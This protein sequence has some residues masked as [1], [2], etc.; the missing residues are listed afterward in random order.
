MRDV[1]S[2]RRHRGFVTVAGA[3]VAGVLVVAFPSKAAGG[4]GDFLDPVQERYE[5]GQTAVMVGYTAPAAIG[6]GSGG[7]EDGPYYGHLR[8]D[9]SAAAATEPATSPHVHPSDVPL[10]PTTITETGRHDMFGLRLSITFTVP[11]DLAPGSYEVFVCNDP[12]THS[13]GHFI[14]GTLN[15]GVDPSEALDRNWLI[16][17][18][19][20]ALLPDHALVAGQTVGR[21]RSGR[22]GTPWYDLHA[23]SSLPADPDP[24][25]PADN[26]QPDPV[27]PAGPAAVETVNEGPARDVGLGDIAPWL[28]GLAIIVPGWR[29]ARRLLPPSTIVTGPA[30]TSP[31]TTS[32]ATTSPASA[33]DDTDRP[34]EPPVIEL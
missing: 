14:G 12:C 30:M 9:P 6:P 10:G 13:L 7:V 24:A 16:D 23:A 2:T 34:A 19:A 28:A 21:L 18:P 26:D 22:A 11:G 31:A 8:V 3:V 17:D 33:S 25:A 5:R 15:V 1:Q 4:G 29:L 27:P 32:P 20:V